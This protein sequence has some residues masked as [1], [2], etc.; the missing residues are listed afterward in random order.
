MG[1]GRHGGRTRSLPQ[2][3][4][5]VAVREVR[6]HYF[7]SLIHSDLPVQ[8]ATVHLSSEE[9]GR[10]HPEY[11]PPNPPPQNRP[12]ASMSWLLSPV[13]T[14]CILAWRH[15]KVHCVVLLAAV[16]GILFLALL[17]FSLPSELSH[18]LFNTAG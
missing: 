15:Y 18:K 3:S 5:K 8:L 17:F 16:L 1:R 14:M 7:S 9:R 10:N 6:L 2:V 4:K 11:P 12:N 13:R